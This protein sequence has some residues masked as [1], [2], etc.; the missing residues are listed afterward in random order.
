MLAGDDPYAIT[1]I[2]RD[3]IAA[4][5]VVKAGAPK[6]RVQRV[7]LAE[8]ILKTPLLKRPVWADNY[9]KPASLGVIIDAKRHQQR[10]KKRANAAS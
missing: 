7:T 1:R 2:L 4:T 5:P 3:M 8:Q 10:A 9:V 6:A